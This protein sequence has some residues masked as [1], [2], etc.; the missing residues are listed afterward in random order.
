MTQPRIAETAS[1]ISMVPVS[2][3]LGGWKHDMSRLTRFELQHAT[4]ERV[5]FQLQLNWT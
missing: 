3:Y 4:A 1:S 5:A 2:V